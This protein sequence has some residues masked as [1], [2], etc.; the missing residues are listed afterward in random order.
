MRLKADIVNRSSSKSINLAFLNEDVPIIRLRGP[1][2]LL[3]D[4][5]VAVLKSKGLVL[6]WAPVKAYLGRGLQAVDQGLKGGQR[7]RGY[8]ISGTPG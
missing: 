3:V 4:D 7:K 1:K 2:I 5:D 6:G 8:C